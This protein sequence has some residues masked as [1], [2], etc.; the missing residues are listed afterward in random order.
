MKK[1]TLLLLFMLSPLIMEAFTF[2]DDFSH[3]LS[4]HW[5]VIKNEGGTAPYVSWLKGLKLT[6]KEYDVHNAITLDYEF[7]TEN[8][9]FVLEF[10]H[11]AYGGDNDNDAANGSNGGN[12]MAIVLF[13]SSVGETPDCGAF[14]GALGYAQRRNDAKGIQQPGFEGGWIGVGLDEYGEYAN[15]NEG[16]EEQDGSTTY[17]EDYQLIVPDTVAIRGAMGEDRH[18]GYR[19]LA[20]ATLGESLSSTF[21][22]WPGPGDKYR[23][24][25]DSTTSDHLY[26]ELERD[27]GDGYQ[28]VIPKFDAMDPSYHQGPKPRY[29]RLAFVAS[30]G[31][32]DNSHSID[33][34]KIKADSGWPYP[35]SHLSVS[36]INVTEGDEGTTDATFTLKLDRP[37][38]SKDITVDYTTVD[39]TAEDENGNNDYFSQSGTVTIA[40]GETEATVTIKVDG[41]FQDES[42]ETFILK[43]SNPQNAVLD[44]TNATA[45]IIDDDSYSNAD[46]YT[47]ESEAYI[48][49]SD[50]YDQS[51]N[52]VFDNPTDVNKID[53]ITAQNSLVKKDLY[54]VNINAIGYGVADNFIWGFDI[55]NFKLTRT[56]IKQNVLSWKVPGLPDYHFH[57]ADVSPQGVLYLASAYLRWVDGVESNGILRLYRVDVDPNSHTFRKALPPIELDNKNLYGAD[58]TF[59]PIDEKIYMVSRYDGD[60]YRIDPESGHV[61]DIGN[62]GFSYADSHVQFF[63]RD[64]YFYFFKS[65]DFYRVDLRDPTHPDTKAVHFSHLPLPLNGDGARCA[66]APMGNQVSIFGTSVDEGNTSTTQMTFTIASDSPAP[67]GGIDVGYQTI[68]GSAIAGSDYIEQNGTATIPAGQQYTTV[69][70]DVVGDTVYEPDESFDVNLTGTTVGT[71]KQPLATGLIYNDDLNQTVQLRL[72]VVDFTSLFEWD[73]NITTKI[74]NKPFKLT[75]IAKNDFDGT[76]LKDVNITQL[77]LYSCSG[78]PIRVPWWK[79]TPH[80]TDTNGLAQLPPLQEANSYP[81]VKVKAYATME[82]MNGTYVQFSSDSFAIR[83]DHYSF[84]LPSDIKA[85]EEFNLTI[86]AKDALGNT[87]PTYNETLNSSY[88]IIVKEKKPGCATA[89]LDLMG[90]NFINGVLRKETNYPEVGDLNLTIHE[91][92][93]TAYA[94]E[95]RNDT[96]FSDLLIPPAFAEIKIHPEKIALSWELLGSGSDITYFSNDPEAM[97]AMLKIVLA[98]KGKAGNVLQNYSSGCYANDIEVKVTYRVEG[99]A[100]ESPH[101]RVH[102]ANTSSYI[103][104]KTLHLP[105][106]DDTFS[107]TL[108]RS[109]FQNGLRTEPLKINFARADNVPMEPLSLAIKELNISEPTTHSSLTKTEKQNFYFARAHVIDQSAKGDQLDAKVYYEVYCKKCDKSKYPYAAGKESM[110]SV[111]WYILPQPVYTSLDSDIESGSLQALS[112]STVLLQKIG[113]DKIRIKPDKVPAIIGVKYTPKSYLRYDRIKNGVTAHRFKARFSGR[114]GEWA[115]RGKLGSTLDTN[116]SRRGGL[117]KMDW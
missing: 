48:Y 21:S 24:T 109:K 37:H 46:H 99:S 7:P 88:E 39:E 104:D 80:I 77:D 117:M 36:D 73:R 79:D 20:A 86:E 106:G 35:T 67:A 63:D 97:G 53:L 81:C 54:P 40:Q 75:V 94:I 72:N 103:A 59:S 114:S 22:W 6:D 68:D 55:E 49:S 15:Y 17:S 30:T 51:G 13:D 42:D 112:G 16:R 70:V 18:H 44:D 90:A 61:E 1:S 34:V 102:D 52:R 115:G 4:S 108:S 116:V 84:T 43:L 111:F 26:I 62:T 27:T 110:D 105:M 74:A 60:I 89:S 98:A 23:L 19:K 2:S 12:G 9:K 8:N 93:A 85:G 56:D 11:Y 32:A 14:G 82:D 45:R 95:D 65:D 58:F 28:S 83:P 29:F 38:P 64:G 69:T 66:Y 76:P 41:D 25:V 113:C 71:I 31:G 87:I 33:D 47:C 3:G 107:Y 101:I 57:I 10:T 50:P 92:N 78:S 100:G 5:R 96:A 91:I